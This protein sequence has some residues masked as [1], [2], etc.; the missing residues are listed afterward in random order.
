MI[1]L[2]GP[3]FWAL[4]SLFIGFA[5]AYP[6]LRTPEP[7]GQ[8]SESRF[9]GEHRFASQYDRGGATEATGQVRTKL[10]STT[11]AAEFSEPGQPAFDSVPDIRQMQTELPEWVRPVSGLDQL[12]ADSHRDTEPAPQVRKLREPRPWLDETT[13][14]SN[15][16]ASNA[17]PGR[18]SSAMRNSLLG[19]PFDREALDEASTTSSHLDALA[20]TEPNHIQTLLADSEWPDQSYVT[21]GWRDSNPAPTYG[22]SE[23]R[24]S[25]IVGDSAKARSQI[26]SGSTEVANSPRQPI[27]RAP[28]ITRRGFASGPG[29]LTSVRPWQGSGPDDQ[30]LPREENAQQS[31]R[32]R[33]FIYQ[34]GYNPDES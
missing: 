11:S 8:H 6:F 28:A 14:G 30:K 13:P 24:R 23:N 18:D 10:A 1:R 34:P 17:A 3:R 26:A 16:T 22:D 12:L 9:E 31:E 27:V 5:I 29:S 25:A 20:V 32:K 19:S 21:K 2:H 33:R 4:A 15:A 7:Q